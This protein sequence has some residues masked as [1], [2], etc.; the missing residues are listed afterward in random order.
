MFYLGRRFSV[1]GLAAALVFLS[2]PAFMVNS[3]LEMVDVPGISLWIAAIA[4]FIYGVDKYR[5]RLLVL[6]GV[7]MLLTIF[8]F[9]QGISVLI[10][11][12]LY[13]L[14]NRRLSLKTAIPIIIPSLLLASYIF[15]VVEV[16]G[17]PPRLSHRYGLPHT[18]WDIIE[19]FRGVV[20]LIG[21]T[22]VF[23]L[24]ALVSFARNWRAAL[25]FVAAS[26]ATWTWLAVRYFLYA[27]PLDEMILLAIFLSVGLT[28]CYWIF[29]SV[30]HSFL[31][32]ARETTEG[33]DIIWI[34]AW[35]FGV[36]IYCSFFLPYAAPRYFLPA[37]PAIV[38][39]LLVS[40]KK[41]LKG[42]R[43]PRFIM[44]VA[45]VCL[46]LVISVPV[47][48]SY[49][50]TAESA[51]TTVDWVSEKYG[52][53]PGRI[54][55][56][57]EFGFSFYMKRKGYSMMPNIEH[58][59][60]TDTGNPWLPEN[61][62]PGDLIVTSPL[63]VLWYPYPE[64]MKRIRLVETKEV[65]RKIPVSVSDFEKRS[66]WGGLRGLF[67]PYTFSQEPVD[68]VSVWRVDKDPWPLPEELKINYQEYDGLIDLGEK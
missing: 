45:V 11:A 18:R 43:K 68:S 12:I 53:H 10:L 35:F 62:E 29:E 16:S 21:S 8:T 34:A 67:L 20:T 5:T 39:L 47:S 55:Y 22:A 30:V 48:F 27:D 60:Y 54:W 36:L 51:K 2:A 58:V 33:K 23:P 32:K 4:S 26:C 57:S 38:L 13:L 31:S 37:V 59:K 19:R 65:P 6:S 14:I 52:S 40:W 41:V 66:I 28:I 24:V 7:L 49:K 1:S 3:H 9:Y 46:S 63:N 17:R 42:R 61:P 50:E 44:T 15:Y 64:V 25:V 56:N